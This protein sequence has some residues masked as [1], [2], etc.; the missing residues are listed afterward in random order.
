M[1]TLELLEAQQKICALHAQRLQMALNK[2]KPSLPFN[3]N[4]LSN[5]DSEHLGYLELLTNR[6]AKLQDT[7][8][9]KIFPLILEALE[10]QED[11]SKKTFIDILNRLEKLEILPSSDH[12][13][14]MRDIRNHITHEY[15]ENPNIMVVNLNKSI[16]FIEDL[17]SYWSALNTR[18]E[19]LINDQ[20]K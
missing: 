18:I 9:A 6:F 1:R 2:L 15:P 10:E 14:D 3:T 20:K 19:C 16:G 8:G 5:L 7:I 17:L 13:R 11:I 12:W 4:N